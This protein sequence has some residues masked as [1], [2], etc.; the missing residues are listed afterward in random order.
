MTKLQEIV[1]VLTFF[2]SPLT[3]AKQQTWRRFTNGGEIGEEDLFHVLDYI[4]QGKHDEFDWDELEDFKE[5]TSKAL[6]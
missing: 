5:E 3:E 4:I 6:L 2:C 1:L